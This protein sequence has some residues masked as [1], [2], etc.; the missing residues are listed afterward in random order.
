MRRISAADE[1]TASVRVRARC[2][3]R[4]PISALAVGASRERVMRACRRS[5][6]GAISRPTGISASPR[7]PAIQA[8]SWL[9]TG[10]NRYQVPSQTPVTGSQT[11]GSAIPNRPC[12]SIPNGTIARRPVTVTAHCAHSTSRQVALSVKTASQRRQAPF[13]PPAARGTGRYGRP[14]RT[15]V[16]PVRR[17]CAFAAHRRAATSP[18]TRNRPNPSSTRDIPARA[19]QARTTAS[20]PTK[21]ML[22]PRPMADQPA[23]NQLRPWRTP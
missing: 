11:N 7:P 15:P 23:A 18:G 19:T 9:R 4:R 2:S 1:S 20:R 5:T 6:Y 16:F 17:R 3:T 12:A 22:S 14:I 21:N 13:Q 10:T 8:V